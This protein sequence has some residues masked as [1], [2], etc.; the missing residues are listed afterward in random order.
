MIAAQGKCLTVHGVGETE[1]L[2]L[3]A[4]KVLHEALKKADR[5]LMY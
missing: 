1:H 5:I 2:K 3:S 4:M